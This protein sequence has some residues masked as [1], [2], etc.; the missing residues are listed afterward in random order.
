MVRVRFA[1][2]P[3]GFVHVGSLRTAL[4]NDLYALKTG[5]TFVLRIEDTDRTRYVEGAVENLLRSLKWAG[6]EPNEGPYLADDG[7]VKERGA[8]GPYV[9]SKRLD[10]YLK[11]AD[12]LLASGRAYR[13]FCTPERLERIRAEQTAAKQP[14]M[15]DKHCR[16]LT[17]ADTATK[18]AD[19]LPW[20]IR[21]RIPDE[22]VT[23]FVD[24]VRGEVSFENKL[25]DDQVLLKSDGFPT[26]HLANVVD[27]HHMEI[28]HVIRGEEWLPSTPKHVLLYQA[29]GWSLPEF[30]HLPLLLNADK[31]K[32]S[33]RQGD[34]AVEDYK[35]KGY[36]PEA[37]VNFVAF[38][39]WH[40]PGDRELYSKGELA[41]EFDLVKVNKAGAVFNLEKLDWTNGEYLK[42]MPTSE[43]AC[44]AEPFFIE[45][46][47]VKREGETLR[48][49]KT[50]ERAERLMECAVEL[51][52]RRVKTLADFPKSTDYLFGDITV[53][54]AIMVWKKSDATTAKARLAGVREFLTDLPKAA[55]EDAKALEIALMSHIAAQDW[56]N[57]DTLWPL[58]TALSGREA[59]PGPFELAWALG[60]DRTLA[61]IDQAIASLS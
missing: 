45:S 39:G 17:P 59:S 57:G 24:A 11:H 61:R 28:T 19:G 34:V 32:L 53:D 3:T 14:M 21:L 58:R 51:E 9:Q 54:P 25:I 41:A 1:P 33:K 47:L 29:F 38:L 13:C 16:S 18:I 37:L 49:S 42:T 12:E 48:N 40:P 8:Y 23:T 50:G 10:L 36:L 26:Y 44:R 22:G 7:S 5:G 4:Y 27:D 6:M 15:Y 60:R 55:F 2:S 43:I 56:T 30:A 31:S 46:G 20:V 52:R 35:A